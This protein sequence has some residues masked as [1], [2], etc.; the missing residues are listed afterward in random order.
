MHDHDARAR[1]SIACSSMRPRYAMLSGAK[2]APTR[3]APNHARTA[4]GPFGSHTSTLSPARTPR[5]RKAAAARRASAY[6]SPYVQRLT[7]FEQQEVAI[8]ASPQPAREQRWQHALLATRHRRIE[9]WRM[10]FGR[11]L[12]GHRQVRTS[13]LTARRTLRSTQLVHFRA[14]AP[15]GSDRR[16]QRRLP[17]CRRSVQQLDRRDATAQQ[18]AVRPL[19]QREG[20]QVQRAPVLR[21]SVLVT[22]RMSWYGVARTHAPARACATGPRVCWSTPQR[23][24]DVGEAMQA[25]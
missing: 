19:V 5:R 18:P 10:G 14:A 17:L 1:L 12:H 6:V 24:L 13:R 22:R 20:R 25:E 9:P 16:R 4:S 11:L 2:Q 7:V 15:R 8:A 3:L 21:Q 23:R